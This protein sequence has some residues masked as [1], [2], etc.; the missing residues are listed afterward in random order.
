MR[1]IGGACLIA[2]FIASQDRTY[3]Q[4]GEEHKNGVSACARG[5]GHDGRGVRV[6]TFS[7]SPKTP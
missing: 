3:M 4:H 2:T 7:E 5:T 1:G 6:T